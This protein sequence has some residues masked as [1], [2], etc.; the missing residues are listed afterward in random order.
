[1]ALGAKFVTRGAQGPES[2][3]SPVI[4][5]SPSGTLGFLR[6]FLPRIAGYTWWGPYRQQAGAPPAGPRTARGAAKANKDGKDGEALEIVKASKGVA[7]AKVA[8]LIA[9]Q[10]RAKRSAEWV[11]RKRVELTKAN[12]GLMV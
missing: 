4:L 3:R 12:G 2:D 11:R 9:E 8:E 10:L 1:M 6:W 7:N 5:D